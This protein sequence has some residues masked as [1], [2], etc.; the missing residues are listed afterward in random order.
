MRKN[1]KRIL[2]TLVFE[3]ASLL[4]VAILSFVISRAI[5]ADPVL[6]Y[7]PPGPIN[8]VIYDA[9]RRMLGLDKPII[10]QFFRYMGDMLTGQWGI[11]LNLFRGYS[12]FDLIMERIYPTIFLTVI[13]LIIGLF[14]GYLLGNH[15]IKVKSIKGDRI[16]QF[17]SILGFVIPIITLTILFQFFLS[18]INPLLDLVLLWIA[19]SLSITAITTLLVRM[20]FINL[21][22]EPSEKHSTRMFKVL[23]GFSYGIV[24]AFLLQTEIMFSFDGIGDLFLQAISSVDYYVLNA[25]IFL[26]VISFPIF[27]VFILLLF[28]LFGKLKKKH[29]LKQVK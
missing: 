23:V 27:I 25:I 15:S 22:K 26:T 29:I 11:S 28:F 24:L 10:E 7:H 9:I 6:S 14:L 1:T 8:P 18:F 3:L 19:L 13:P 4:F 17:V 21:S 20:Y 2:V 12:V 16:V 5:P